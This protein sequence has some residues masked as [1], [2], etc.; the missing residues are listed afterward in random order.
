MRVTTDPALDW[1]PVWGPDDRTLTYASMRGGGWTAYSRRADGLGP[2]TLLIEERRAQ[3]WPSSWSPDGKTLLFSQFDPETRGDLWV[4]PAGQPRRS[5]CSCARNSARTRRRSRRRQVG[6]LPRDGER[7]ARFGRVARALGSLNHPNVAT[8]HGFESDGDRRFLVMELV[9][10]EDLAARIARG[11]IPVDEAIPLFLQI[12][13]GL[14]AAHE[15]GIST[16]TSSPRTSRSAP[17]GG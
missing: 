6:R 4:V 16:A 3:K 2:E 9:E 5:R 12:A 8:L 15:K 17:T 14:E 10:G 1:Q 7:V 11:P 13:E